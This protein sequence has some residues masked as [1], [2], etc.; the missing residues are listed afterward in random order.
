MN[1]VSAENPRQSRIPEKALQI[2]FPEG[3]AQFRSR[4]IS[5]FQARKAYSGGYF[6]GNKPGG[7]KTESGNIR[8]ASQ[9]GMFR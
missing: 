2:R 6:K 9:W 8:P 4:R 7:L 5:G 3:T 1:Q